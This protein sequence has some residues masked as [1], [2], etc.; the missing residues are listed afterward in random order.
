MKL[1]LI[2][3]FLFIIILCLLSCNPNRERQPITNKKLNSLKISEMEKFDIYDIKSVIP[4]SEGKFYILDGGNRMIWSLSPDFKFIKKFGR[5]GE[6]P[7]EFSNQLIDMKL[8]KNEL[9][10]L[11]EGGFINIFDTSGNFISK[12]FLETVPGT[13]IGGNNLTINENHG[14]ILIGFVINMVNKINKLDVIPLGG[15][16]SKDGT[17]KK[18][19][20]VSSKYFNYPGFFELS[21]VSKVS[22]KIVFTFKSNNQMHIFNSDG[23]YSETK[24]IKIKK[25]EVPKVISTNRVRFKGVSVKGLINLPNRKWGIFIIDPVDG[26]YYMNIYDENLNFL[27][28]QNIVPTPAEISRRLFGVY[29]NGFLY[30]WSELLNSIDIYKLNYNE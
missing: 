10:V 18:I 30:L 25:Y 2:F 15:E 12:V 23:D 6:G 21:Y 7:G 20:T 27:Y 11:E 4:D 22:N 24:M 14:S 3:I 26:F 17:I 29:N 9:F 28:K 8:S 16:Y 13:F 5:K 1:N 19:F